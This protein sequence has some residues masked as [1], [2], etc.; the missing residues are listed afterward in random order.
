[1]IG[2]VLGLT[3]TEGF[4]HAKHILLFCCALISVDCAQGQAADMV[5]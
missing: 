2:P 4:L 3:V 1:M 5:L